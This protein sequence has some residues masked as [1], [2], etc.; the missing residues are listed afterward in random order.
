MHLFYSRSRALILDWKCFLFRRCSTLSVNMSEPH[1]MYAAHTMRR[2]IICHVGPTNSGKTHAALQALMSSK[3]G[4]Y[5]GPLRLLAWEVS[6]SLRSKNVPCDLVTGQERDKMEGSNFVACT[7][8]MLDT[9]VQYE[10]GIIDECQLIGDFSRGW[11]WTKA[12]LGMQARVIHLCGSPSM[13]DIV[14]KLSIRMGTEMEVITYNRLS[15]LNVGEKALKNYKN[16]RKGDCVIGFSRKVLYDIKRQ[17]E[18]ANRDL[19][20]CII[21]GNLPP[22]ARKEQARLFNEENSGYDVLVAS[23]AIG[24]CILDSIMLVVE[25]SLSFLLHFQAWD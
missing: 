19:R 9:S 5:C 18:A 17:I 25:G 15:P 10:A 8:E 12:L 20:C 2:R 1:L 23:D 11:A 7:I 16:I 3:S 4:V 6:E 13:L 24:I 22:A 14:R 21:Y